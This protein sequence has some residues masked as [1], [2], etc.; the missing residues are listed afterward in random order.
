MR[1]ISSWRLK[2]ELLGNIWSWTSRDSELGNIS[3]W[4]NPNPVNMGITS[5]IFI[6]APGGTCRMS[7]HSKQDG[8]A[9]AFISGMWQWHTIRVYLKRKTLLC[10][11]KRIHWFS[12]LE[13]L[14]YQVKAEHG[15]ATSSSPGKSTSSST[16]SSSCQ[17]SK[18]LIPG[19]QSQGWQAVLPPHL[20]HLFW[21]LVWFCCLK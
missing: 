5:R 11:W 15:W 1:N 4:E 19:E 2:E 21:T 18:C 7:W 17:C 3:F 8:R 9:T 14:Q 20:F 13:G 16:S 10:I 6:T 12:N